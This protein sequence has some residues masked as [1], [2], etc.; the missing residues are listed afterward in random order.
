MDSDTSG[1]PASVTGYRVIDLGGTPSD[2]DSIA[3]S[4]D[5]VKLRTRITIDERQRIRLEGVFTRDQL[6]PTS[7][8]D[9][10][11]GELGLTCTQVE[12]WF[13]NR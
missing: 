9:Q 5:T 6:P 8:K 10:L 7:L 4:E 12:N 11:A 3:P 1:L 13:R 2:I